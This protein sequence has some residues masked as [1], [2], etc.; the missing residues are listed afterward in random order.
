M[1]GILG[2]IAEAGALPDEGLAAEVEGV[3]LYFP[4]GL[5]THHWMDNEQRSNHLTPNKEL[6]LPCD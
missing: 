4:V 5:S 1:V 6:S 3:L 2:L